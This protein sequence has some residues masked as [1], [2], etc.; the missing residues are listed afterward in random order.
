VHPSADEIPGAS[1]L[2]ELVGDVT[3]AVRGKEKK[4]RPR[5][6]RPFFQE[7][8]VKGEL[9]LAPN[10]FGSLDVNV[11]GVE[12]GDLAGLAKANG[13]SLE[14]GVLDLEAGIRFG[15]KG[16]VAL[17]SVTTLTW[18]DVSEPKD[19]PI[20]RILHLPAP[21]N[22]VQWVLRDE[23]GSIVVPLDVNV[24]AMPPEMAPVEKMAKLYPELMK[25]LGATLGQIIARALL[26]SP[27]RAL[28]TGKAVL[29]GALSFVPGADLLPLMEK[30]K[31]ALEPIVLRFAAADPAPTTAQLE[32]LNAAIEKLQGDE[33]LVVTLRHAVGNADLA[34]ERVAANPSPRDRRDI[35]DRLASRR[36]DLERDRLAALAEVRASLEARL[37]DDADRARAKARGLEAEVA[38]VDRALDQVYDLERDGA[39]RQADRRTRAACV[40]LG[41]ARL[42]AVR[43]TILRALPPKDA[44]RIRVSR[45]RVEDT[46]A[47]EGTI[48]VTV[49][50]SKKR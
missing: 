30:P 45:P 24:P 10:L 42:D 39:E 37:V 43:A 33:K 49:T 21:L 9:A 15:S 12:L 41:K 47:T 50:Q 44:D 48:T 17:R 7:V 31:P 1:A 40:E 34:R 26:H 4:Q 38:T 29:T 19:G 35:L 32:K 27:F 46:D 5:E 25:T 28:G 22:E 14:D 2:F 18:L 16:D 13:A 11:E 36:A 23:D 6:E 8:A 3:D 20:A